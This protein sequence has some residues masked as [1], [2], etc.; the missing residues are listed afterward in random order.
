MDIVSLEWRL[1]Y[2]NELKDREGP[3]PSIRLGWG[4][5]EVINFE[6]FP[7]ECL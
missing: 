5:T 3:T 4:A 7:I 2:S 1:V 6:F